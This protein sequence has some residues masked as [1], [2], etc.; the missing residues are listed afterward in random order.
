MSRTV[1]PRRVKTKKPSPPHCEVVKVLLIPRT[2]TLPSVL[3]M[4]RPAI[5]RRYSPSR[6]NG[7][8]AAGRTGFRPPLEYS[9]SAR[10][11]LHPAGKKGPRKRARPVEARFRGRDGHETFSGPEEAMPFKDDMVRASPGQ[12][13]RLKIAARR[14][15]ISPLPGATWVGLMSKFRGRHLRI[16]MS[17]SRRQCSLS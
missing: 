4:P 17:K 14:G 3:T 10:P 13:G 1:T 9:R 16:M 7:F 2:P 8:N 15:A 6:F 12:K 5:C 11:Q